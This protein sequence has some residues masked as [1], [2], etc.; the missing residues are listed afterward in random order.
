M[1]LDC[2]ASER[3]FIADKAASKGELPAR[4]ANPDPSQELEH[5]LSSSLILNLCGGAWGR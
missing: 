3:V 1:G 2:T 4:I 5:S